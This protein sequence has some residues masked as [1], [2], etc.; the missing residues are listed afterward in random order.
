VAARE[1][2]RFEAL[3]LVQLAAPEML[4]FGAER[5]LQALVLLDR[6]GFSPP[7]LEPAERTDVLDALLEGGFAPQL[8]TVG[9]LQAFHR[10]TALPCLR[11]TY[12]DSFAAAALLAEIFA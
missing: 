9:R 11:L 2:R 7:H 3:T 5:P 6:D 12:G 10:L 4:P 1:V 8:G